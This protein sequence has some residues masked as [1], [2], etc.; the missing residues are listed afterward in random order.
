MKRILN[1]MS[2]CKQTELSHLD[3]RIQLWSF[4]VPYIYHEWLFAAHFRLAEGFFENTGCNAV[5]INGVLYRDK[6]FFLASNC[7]K[8]IFE[9]GIWRVDYYVKWP[10]RCD[11]G[12]FYCKRIWQLLKNNSWTEKRDLTRLWW[13][14]AGTMPKCKRNLVKR[15]KV[16]HLP[17]IVFHDHTVPFYT[18]YY[19]KN[20][21]AFKKTLR[22]F[23]F[24]K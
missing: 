21:R 23:F 16:F 5:T 19:N 8:E 22:I 24:Q 13:N 6:Q 14:W 7:W 12:F 15:S 4:N 2:I 3:L 9:D 1:F 20:I 18:L 11:T 10:P 17:D